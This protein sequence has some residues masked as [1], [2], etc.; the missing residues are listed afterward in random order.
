M[1]QEQNTTHSH[2]ETTHSSSEF[3]A[4]APKKNNALLYLVIIAIIVILG[5]GAYVF[6]TESNKGEVVA[7]VNG[8]K[9]YKAEVDENTERIIQI[10]KLQ[11]QPAETEEAL[12]ALANM[13]LGIMID[14]MILIDAAEEAGYSVSDDE[15]ET[16]YQEEVALYDSEEVFVEQLGTINLTV[17]ELKENMHDELLVKKYFDAEIEDAN[18]G[19]TQ[20]EVEAR[21]D[22]YVEANSENEQIE[23]Q[24][25][26][27]LQD[28]IEDVIAVEKERIFIEELVDE[29]KSDAEI[30]EMI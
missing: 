5:I 29:L 9:L 25:L 4:N 3:Q 11:G 27:V 2:E 14:N 19:V 6:K 30:E 12:A 20:E 18:L 23:I 21:Y 28:D 1:E 15:I 22:A 13:S 24:P 10:A 16:R 17:E 7:V 26:E 8:E